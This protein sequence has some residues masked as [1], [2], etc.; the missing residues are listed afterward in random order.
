LAKI[1]KHGKSSEKDLGYHDDLGVLF[2]RREGLRDI[3][4]TYSE[5]AQRIP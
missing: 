1:D 3:D 2:E 4:R 5:L